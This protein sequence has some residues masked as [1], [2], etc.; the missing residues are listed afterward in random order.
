MR[1]F[2]DYSYPDGWTC[3]ACSDEY[4]PPKCDD[5][6]PARPL[7]PGEGTVCKVCRGADV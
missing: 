6:M 2:I 5:D 7:D 4:G 1:E 3:Q